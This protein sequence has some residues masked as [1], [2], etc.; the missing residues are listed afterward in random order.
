MVKTL[1]SAISKNYA[2]ALMDVASEDNSYDKF[3]I[4]LGE[5]YDVLCSSKDLQI[6]MTNSSISTEKKIQILSEI[7]G[8]K[9]EKK[10]INFLKILVEKNRFNEFAAIKKSFSDMVQKLSNKRTV[11]ITQPIKLNFEDKT[12][13][14]FKLEHKF[15][16]EILPVWKVDKSLIAGLTFKYDDCVIDTSL[17]AKLEN[18]S[19]N[20]NR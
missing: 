3:E 2:T 4:Q 12:T 13:A 7:F 8:G 15:N 6:V 1:I 5:I 10:L 19:K 17:R 14:L 9:I 16:C 18:L 20:I 11:E